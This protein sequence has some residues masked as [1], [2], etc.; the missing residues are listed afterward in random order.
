[1]QHKYQKPELISLDILFNVHGADGSC[2]DETS[3]G[4]DIPCDTW[5]SPE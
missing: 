1:M 3:E 4:G 5:N 2:W